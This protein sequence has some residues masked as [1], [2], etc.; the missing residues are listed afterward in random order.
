MAK[1][2]EVVAIMGGEGSAIDVEQQNLSS[3]SL[4]TADT[5]A[6]S[7]AMGETAKNAPLDDADLKRLVIMVSKK[8]GPG[9]SQIML[10]FYDIATMRQRSM[11]IYDG[12][13][14]KS[15][16]A[17]ILKK[18]AISYS[19][20]QDGG[21]LNILDSLSA[22]AD[23]IGH[24]TG[25]SSNILDVIMSMFGKGPEAVEEIFNSIRE[26]GYRMTIMYGV[27]P[28]KDTV[29]CVEEW[30]DV[31]GTRA[32]HV[33]VL[34]GFWGDTADAESGAAKKVPFAYWHGFY[35]PNGERVGG[36]AKLR[37]E[38]LVKEGHAAIVNFPALYVGTNTL[39]DLFDLRFLDAMNRPDLLALGDRSAVR[40]YVNASEKAFTEGNAGKL[41]G[42]C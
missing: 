35:T 29:D 21:A 39:V 26:A 33:V 6:L 17:R 28:A 4:L 7:A 37:I 34:N 19:L 1:K 20:V 11:V 5:T 2:E 40:A 3:T 25:A 23:I 31:V 10:T 32:D 9:K 30:L 36:T 42:L 14:K 24:D 18:Q 12:E 22:G 41:L 27:S 15:R 8:G 16:T 13:G 38:Q